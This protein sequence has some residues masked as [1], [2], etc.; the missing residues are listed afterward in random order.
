MYKSQNSTSLGEFKQF[1]FG[2]DQSDWYWYK[3]NYTDQKG[4][5][6]E[7][8]SKPFFVATASNGNG[9]SF[10]K[11]LKRENNKITLSFDKVTNDPDG[12]FKNATNY[13]WLKNNAP[14]RNSS[15]SQLS[16]SISNL[17]DKD[18][19][20]LSLSYVDAQGFSNSSISETFIFNK[21]NKGSSTFS[22]DGTND[23]GNTLSINEDSVDPDGKG[24]L[25]YK[26]QTSSDNSN[27]DEVGTSSTYK[28]T[29]SEEGKSIK[30]VIT[31]NDSQGFDE[32]VTT[33]RS[34]IPLFDN[35]D[36]SFS[37][38]GTAAVGNTLSINQDTAD[39]DGTGALSY[40][41][42]T[43]N[44]NSTWSVV[45]TNATYKVT[46]SEE[47]KSIKAVITYKDSEGFDETVTTSSSKIPFFDNGDAS[48]SIT[49]TAAVGNT[50]SINEDSA[51]PDGTG[52]LSYS[53]Q[54]SNDNSTWSVVGT[55]ST[56]TV[57]M[58]EEGKYIR[59]VISYQDAQGFDE[60]V[61]TSTSSISFIDSGDASFS[62]TGTAAVGN[63]LS[64]S[65]DSADPD[66]SGTLSYSWQTSSDNS[67]WSVVGTNATYTV[68]AGE[69]GKY[70]RAVI[71]YQD[72]QGF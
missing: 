59:A 51:D 58:S 60:T 56:Y 12:P 24:I 6:T 16:Y 41:W 32:I 31:Y 40:S 39:P 7:I 34:S 26:W 46:T 35:G 57:G 11:A 49:G 18:K 23:V 4:F 68:R 44:D 13:M 72:A 63:T 33:S 30:A 55:N 2:G 48:F 43:S 3:A 20:S 25:S 17:N 42:Q 70:I 52:T 1:T 47:G 29:P 22:I 9:K 65:E 67:T 71:S 5:Q 54:T 21:E 50:L 69:D 14:I 45:G 8:I 10:I 61:T 62:I 64:I 37:I 19:I 28:V 15:N 36:A 53:W 38:I 66:G 27:W